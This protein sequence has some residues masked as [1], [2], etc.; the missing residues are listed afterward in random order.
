MRNT[1][2]VTCTSMAIECSFKVEII[3]DYAAQSCREEKTI[4]CGHWHSSYGHSK[5]E[6]KGSEFGPDADFSPYY[7]PG[8]IALD[9]CTAHSGKVNVIVIEDEDLSNQDA[10]DERFREVTQRILEEHKAA[11]LELAK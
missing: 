9:A 3:I 8:V 7:G 1:S 4:L 5:Y 11:F 10:E 6:G 2:A